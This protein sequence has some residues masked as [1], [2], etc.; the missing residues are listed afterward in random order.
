MTNQEIIDLNAKYLC[1]TYARSPV[2]FVRGRGCRLW[3]ADGKAYLDFFASLAVMNLGQCHSAVVQA[4]Q[5]QVA[6][7]APVALGDE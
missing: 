3:D 5:E 2:A 6:D 4:V 1:T 7:N